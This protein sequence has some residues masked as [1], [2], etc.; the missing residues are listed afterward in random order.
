VTICRAH[1]CVY[2]SVYMFS[3]VVEWWWG[4]HHSFSLPLGEEG[5]KENR[6]EMQLP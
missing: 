5:N 2:F 4:H 1:V 6:I 3:F